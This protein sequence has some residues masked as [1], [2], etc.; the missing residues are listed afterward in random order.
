MK[1]RWAQTLG[2][3]G[4]VALAASMFLP[5]TVQESCFWTCGAPFAI[6]PADYAHH[7]RNAWDETPFVV[8]IAVAAAFAM[9]LPRR[10]RIWV[11]VAAAGLATV[12]ALYTLWAMTFVVFAKVVGVGPGL[13]LGLGGVIAGDLGLMLSLP[14][15]AGP[16][17]PGTEG[18]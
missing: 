12:K 7:Y 3:V 6:S 9:L 10:G 1:A 5:W 8:A 15:R 4:F 11:G 17:P 18:D 14:L 16:D 13:F 2:A